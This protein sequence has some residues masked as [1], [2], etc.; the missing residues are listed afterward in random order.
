MADQDVAAGR[1][2]ADAVR[3]NIKTVQGGRLD[4]G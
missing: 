3:G 1:I 4:A 2:E